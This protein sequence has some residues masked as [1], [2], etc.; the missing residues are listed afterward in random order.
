LAGSSFPHP[1]PALAATARTYSM[2][3]GG[4]K[5]IA[6]RYDRHAHTFLSAIFL[7]VIVACWINL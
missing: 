2:A 5:R 7:A 3:L 6:L 4:G 1:V